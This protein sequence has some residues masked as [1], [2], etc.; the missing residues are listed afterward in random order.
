MNTLQ[1][2]RILKA[3]VDG[4][5]SYGEIARRADVDPAELSPLSEI[6][7]RAIQ[8]MSG[9]Y[10][11]GHEN[12]KPV[13]LPPP[14]N[15]Y[16]DKERGIDEQRPE[17]FALEAVQRNNVDRDRCFLTCR[18]LGLDADTAETAIDNVSMPWRETNG[19]R[20]YVR[21]EGGKYVLQDKPPVKLKRHLERLLEQVAG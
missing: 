10:K 8:L 2:D 15:P 19:W 3:I 7:D 11:Y 13:G 20:S 17:Y 14:P 18:Q 9:F 5:I 16:F 21:E 12:M 4:E 1:A 6:L